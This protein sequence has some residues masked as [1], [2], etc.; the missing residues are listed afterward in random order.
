MRGIMT[1]EQVA[2]YL[3]VPEPTAL[4][5]L[6]DNGIAPIDFGRGRGRGKRW[7]STDVQMAVD[8]SVQKNAIKPRRRQGHNTP[9]FAG[10]STADIIAELTQ[11]AQRQ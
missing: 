3:Q 11:S 5:W 9:L 4:E 7:R 1:T 2:D 10:R 6:L 8:A